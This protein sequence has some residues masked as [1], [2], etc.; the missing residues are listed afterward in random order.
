M[1]VKLNTWEF[2][3]QLDNLVDYS[4]GFLEGAES[5]KK[6]FLDN[7][8]KGT[9]EA[10]KL[11]IDAMARSNPQSLH[12]V[13]EWSKTGN[14]DGRLFNVQYRI[15]NLGLSFDSSF[16]QSTSVQ[17]GSYEPFYNKA[18][19]MEDGVPVVIR[20]KGNNP[21]VFEDNGVTVYTKKPIV[22]QFP[23]GREVKGSYEKTFDDFITKYFA[24]SFL[25]AT[26]LYDYLSNPKIYKKNLKSGVKGGK[27]VGQSTGFSWITNAKVEVE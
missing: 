2:E 18:K 24:Q 17:S 12:H 10:L 13:Y 3:K 1:R 8:G 23:G 16:K 21:L 5:G 11:Y 7:L 14:R 20:P 19:I 25:T 9:V 15:T 4:L 6:I 27:S 22:N 26:G